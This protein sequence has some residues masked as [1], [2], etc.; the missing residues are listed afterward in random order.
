[1]FAVVLD[2]LGWLSQLLKFWDVVLVVLVL[3]S[4]GCMYVAR[5]RALP[6]WQVFWRVSEQFPGEVCATLGRRESVARRLGR[7]LDKSRPARLMVGCCD[8]N[9][10][11]AVAELST[12]AEERA[13][14]LS[15]LF[16]GVNG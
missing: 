4:L 11:E 14:V 15:G 3:L 12:R 6:E 1:M 5:L 7:R 13:L 2:F 8:V 10:P 16:R 9:N